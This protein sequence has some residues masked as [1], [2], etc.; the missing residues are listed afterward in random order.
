MKTAKALIFT[1]LA[2]GTLLRRH[3]DGTF[4]PVK[5][6]TDIGR[7]KALRENEIEKMAASDPDHPALDATFWKSVPK[8]PRKEAISIKLDRDI[9]QF[10]RK[11]GRGYQ[12][13]INAV[14]RRFV[15]LHRKAG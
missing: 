1:R 7:I 3:R 10:F 4:R 9:L 2:D 5:D 8:I 13:R 12:T 6:Q 14:L 15:D 11:Q